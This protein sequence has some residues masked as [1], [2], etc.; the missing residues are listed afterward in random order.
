MPIWLRKFVYKEIYDF[1][2]KEKKEYEKSVN[3]REQINANTDLQT[4][5]NIK[6]QMKKAEI[7]DF[8]SKIKKPKK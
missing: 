7:P 4:L 5:N 8:V 2:E 3:G 1:Y 6:N